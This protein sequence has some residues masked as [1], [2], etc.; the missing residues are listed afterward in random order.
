M[1]TSGKSSAL[2]L[3][4]IKCSALKDEKKLMNAILEGLI[5][6]EPK[7]FGM[8][9]EIHSNGK[10][11]Q[12]R[13]MR[14]DSYH[15]DYIATA[16]RTPVKQLHA[17]VCKQLK[18]DDP[19]SWT[20]DV[21][22]YYPQLV[23]I[24]ETKDATNLKRKSMETKEEKRIAFQKKFCGTN[25]LNPD[26]YEWMW[27]GIQTKNES[28]DGDVVSPYLHIPIFH[29]V[30]DEHKHEGFYYDYWAQFG[31]VINAWLSH[32]G[33][34]DHYVYEA[35]ELDRGMSL[36]EEQVENDRVLRLDKQ[37]LEFLKQK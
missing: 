32:N 37:S 18:I 5:T 8:S 26:A 23:K 2:I 35:G 34:E 24:E 22:V 9:L 30:G 6:M 28:E 25:V 21:I 31:N 27:L 15:K 1:S 10:M 14:L 3:P 11:W 7:T 16:L 13:G 17:H 4:I 33:F 12:T 19:K 20:L 29:F 36:D